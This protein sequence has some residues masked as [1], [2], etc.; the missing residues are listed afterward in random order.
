MRA[1]TFSLFVLLLALSP[2][3]RTA[4]SVLPSVTVWKSA[5]C[6][7]C[8]NWIKHMQAA[9]FRVESHDLDDLDK[10]KKMA[11]IPPRFQSCH[12]ARVGGYVL[13]GH[14]PAKDEK[15]L[16]SER[17]AAHG[18]AVPGMPAGSPGMEGGGNDPYDVLLFNPDGSAR[19]F[20]SYR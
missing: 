2:V 12:T 20:S 17:P 9:G 8:K 16:L 7:C 1:L 18:L 11:A 15:R 19:V 10:I 3:E 4:A 13:E 6:G 14:V 5:A